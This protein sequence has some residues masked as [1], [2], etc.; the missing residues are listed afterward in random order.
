MAQGMTRS[1]RNARIGASALY[2]V[3]VLALLLF[4]GG[5]AF[6]LAAVLGGMLLGAF[7]TFT[8][9]SDPEPR[10]MRRERRGR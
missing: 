7:Y 2:G 5:G 6:V 9:P 4:V 10:M 1:R 8:A 3:V